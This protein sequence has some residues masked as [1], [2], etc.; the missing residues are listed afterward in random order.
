MKNKLIIIISAI[1]IIA[2][3]ILLYF[4]TKEKPMKHFD[5]PSTIVVNNNTNIPK[6]DTIMMVIANKIFLMD[7]LRIDIYYMTIELSTPDIQVDMYLMPDIYNKNK[8]ILFVSELY[9]K[10]NVKEH[11]AHEMAHL[12][13]YQDGSLKYISVD[14]S[15]MVYNNK[16]IYYS[17]VP[18]EKRPFEID[19][20]KMQ[21]EI[22]SRLNKILYK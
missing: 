10:E 13:Q 8:Y 6:M 22:V 18:Y 20:F 5:F 1:L 16:K 19:A 14:S 12:K 11:L 21:K 15:Y 4:L 3:I 7:T 9:R 17:Q 2:A